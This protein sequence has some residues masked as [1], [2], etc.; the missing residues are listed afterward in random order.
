[1]PATITSLP[2]ASKTTMTFTA[3]DGVYRLSPDACEIDIIDQLNARQSQLEVML[4][5]TYCEPGEKFRQMNEVRQDIYMG[6]CA[7]AAKEIQQLTDLLWEL[8]SADK[9]GAA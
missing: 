2:C 8:R 9:G 7:S 6:A 3:A 4:A 1:M 5:M